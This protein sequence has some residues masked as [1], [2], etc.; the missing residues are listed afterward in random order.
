MSTLIHEIIPSVLAHGIDKVRSN[1]VGYGAVCILRPEENGDVESSCVFVR[2]G[3]GL[4]GLAVRRICRIGGVIVGAGHVTN[5]LS[6]WNNYAASVEE[7]RSGAQQA[8]YAVAFSGPDEAALA[9]RSFA[10]IHRVTAMAAPGIEPIGFK[11]SPI[12]VSRHTTP[13]VFLRACEVVALALRE[14]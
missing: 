4:H 7:V 8:N 2:M 1:F 6:P 5:E 12:D 11:G 13:K 14:K 10:Q 9:L 3:K